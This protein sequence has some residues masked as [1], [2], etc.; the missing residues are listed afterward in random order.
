MVIDLSRIMRLLLISLLGASS[1]TLTGCEGDEITVPVSDEPFLYLV[2]GE[3]TPSQIYRLTFGQHAL[4]MTVGTPT[5]S[6]GHRAAGRFEMR[7]ASDGALFGW[8]QREGSSDVGG[9]PALTLKAPNFF[10]PDTTSGPTLGASALE[11]GGT[12]TLYIET[13]GEVI[14]GR[15]TI[16]ETFTAKYVRQDGRKIAVWPSVAGAA[17]YTIEFDLDNGAI[18]ETVVQTDTVLPLPEDLSSDGFLEIRAMDPNMFEYTADV[19]AVRAGIDN[20][21]G[22]FGAVSIDRLGF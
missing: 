13:L 16:P 22:V 17:G 21:F 11:P 4:L 12:Y 8:L 9:Y 20:G 5:E 1:A 18:R 15:V 6:V 10:L 3:R 14:E 19:Q 7:R 2:L